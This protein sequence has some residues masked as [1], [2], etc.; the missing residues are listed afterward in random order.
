[1]AFS[2]HVYLRVGICMISFSMLMQKNKMLA[3][4]IRVINKTNGSYVVFL[5]SRARSVKNLI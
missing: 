5:V 4:K 1:M 2:D 3:I